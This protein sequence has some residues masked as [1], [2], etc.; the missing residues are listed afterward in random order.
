MANAHIEA[1]SYLGKNDSDIFNL[2]YAKGYSVKE[3]VNSIKNITNINFKTEIV[4]RREGDPAF[5]VADNNKI[6][7]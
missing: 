1:I 4:G 6:F 5:L 3:I 7:R 2:G